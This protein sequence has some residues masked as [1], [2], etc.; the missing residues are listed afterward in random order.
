M[1]EKNLCKS[2]WS[3]YNK[4]TQWA[5][6]SLEKYKIFSVKIDI[7]FFFPSIFC[8]LCIILIVI[9]VC[10]VIYTLWQNQKCMNW[11]QK[12]LLKIFFQVW[13]EMAKKDALQAVYEYRWQIY[14]H[15]SKSVL[16]ENYL[17]IM[18]PCPNVLVVKVL[19]V[20]LHG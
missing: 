12:D 15:I 8:L 3:T 9:V 17:Y 13:T 16:I 5:I 14:L 19:D 6:K 10:I 1:R 2:R 7:R 4:C 20:H 18:Y 11:V